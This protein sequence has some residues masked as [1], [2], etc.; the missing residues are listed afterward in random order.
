M[1]KLCKIL[2][3]SLLRGISGWDGLLELERKSQEEER[4]ERGRKRRKEKVRQKKHQERRKMGTDKSPEKK[5]EE[6][7]KSVEE[8]CPCCGRPPP[9][10]ACWSPALQP[11]LSP[12]QGWLHNGCGWCPAGGHVGCGV[13]AAPQRGWDSTPAWRPERSQMRWRL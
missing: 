3:F 5:Q 12:G 13:G 11:R 7:K 10:Q 6:Y 8:K 4:E 9:P 2:K 1:E